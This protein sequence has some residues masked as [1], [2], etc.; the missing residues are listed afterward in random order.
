MNQKIMSDDDIEICIDAQNFF[1]PN[2]VDYIASKELFWHLTPILI[3]NAKILRGRGY[4]FYAVNHTRGHCYY[5][6]RVITIPVWAMVKS[7]EYK[8]WYIAHEIAHG[9]A[10]H[11]AHHGPAFMT[12]LIRLCPANAIHFEL[13]YKP[14]LAANAGIVSKGSYDF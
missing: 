9:F 2:K 14:R 13:G 10:G 3:S 5:S 8:Q 11:S 4:T 1:I 12:E 7:K 6:R